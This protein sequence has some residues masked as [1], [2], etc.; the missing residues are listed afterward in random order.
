VNVKS[1]IGD[2]G[3]R[4]GGRTLKFDILINTDEDQRVVAQR[5]HEAAKGPKK[6]MTL[7]MATVVD[8][9]EA[10]VVW[11]SAAASARGT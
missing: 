6:A 4:Y 8:P 5:L 2:T 7:I 9:D 3:I 1:N 11:D 10:K